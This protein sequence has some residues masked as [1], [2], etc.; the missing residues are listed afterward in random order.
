MDTAWL[1]LMHAWQHPQL[2]AVMGAMTWLGSLFVLLPLAVV[3]GWGR[4]GGTLLPAAV[5]GASALAHAI[6]WLVDRARPDIYPSLIGMPVDA[7]FPSA[8]A[9]Q[10]AAFVTAL[11]LW[12]G[13][14]GRIGPMVIG[15]LLVLAVAFS[16]T[17]L[18]VHFLSDVLF[19]VTAGVLW[20]IALHA[21]PVW[22]R[23]A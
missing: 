11:L 13:N 8:H 16:R 5:L 12:S 1:A 22:K 9:M 20:A 2:T 10:A 3:A 19:G 6:K 21:L 15:A 7:S 17:Y 4:A 18:Q 23:E 14:A